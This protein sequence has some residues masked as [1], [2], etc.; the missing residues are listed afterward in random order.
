[1]YTYWVVLMF[2]L[3]WCLHKSNLW[4]IVG[5]NNLR[6]AMFFKIEMIQYRYQ[7]IYSCSTGL[8]LHYL[9]ILVIKKKRYIYVYI[10]NLVPSGQQWYTSCNININSLQLWLPWRQTSIW[11]LYIKR[12]VC[13]A[14][15]SLLDHLMP[16]KRGLMWT[17]QSS[18]VAFDLIDL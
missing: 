17:W 6:K 16:I 9:F 18:V 10:F 7:S 12:Q 3:C 1:M 13:P 4:E 5:D 11:H 8:C 14:L 2:F 15:P